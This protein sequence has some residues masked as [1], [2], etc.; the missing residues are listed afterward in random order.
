MAHADDVDHFVCSAF[1]FA[2]GHAQQTGVV[3]HCLATG[4]IPRHAVVFGEESNFGQGR[5]VPDGLSQQTCGTGSSAHD[6]QQHFDQGAL[7]RAVRSD[8]PEDFPSLHLQVHA[9][10][11]VDAAAVTLFKTLGADGGQRGASFKKK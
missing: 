3:Q 7:S 10:Q 8:E 2:L 9:A 5:S 4:E 6:G 1:S 11:G